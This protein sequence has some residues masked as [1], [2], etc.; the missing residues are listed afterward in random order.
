MNVRGLRFCESRRS[1]IETDNIQL[2][3][4]IVLSTDV[5]VHHISRFKHTDAHFD[6]NHGWRLNHQR[7]RNVV[8]TVVDFDDD[9]E[10]AETGVAVFVQQ[11]FDFQRRSITHLRVP[12]LRE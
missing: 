9:F 8:V 4:Q 6:F 12:S 5:F 3:I 1:S 2:E 11:L 7:F 10:L